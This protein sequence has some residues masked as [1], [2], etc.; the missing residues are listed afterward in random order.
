[1]MFRNSQFFRSVTVR[2]L[3]LHAGLAAIAVMTMLLGCTG[4]G[5]DSSSAK[6]KR[7]ILLTNGDD[8]FWDA[9]RSGMEKAAEDFDLATV[10]L[11][12]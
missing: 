10:N 6:T 3:A 1:M 4:T 2:C 12:S 7:I 11:P 8:P 5:S 9:M